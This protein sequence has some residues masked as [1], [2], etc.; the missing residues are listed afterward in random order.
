MQSTKISALRNKS[1]DQLV[2]EDH[3]R[4]ERELILVSAIVVGG[5]VVGMIES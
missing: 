3:V 5:N 1:F 2:V 4:N